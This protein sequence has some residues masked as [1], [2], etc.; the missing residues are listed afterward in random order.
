MNHS[1]RSTRFTHG[2]IVLLEK[3]RSLFNEDE[4][5]ARGVVAVRDCIT[6]LENG[7]ENLYKH[8]SAEQSVPTK[9]DEQKWEQGYD[10]QHKPAETAAEPESKDGAGVVSEQAK[11]QSKDGAGVVS[12]PEK[13]QNREGSGVS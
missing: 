6:F 12:G 3:A 13:S 9:E 7:L 5:S 10:E 11:S 1:T 2:G 4:Y 8:K